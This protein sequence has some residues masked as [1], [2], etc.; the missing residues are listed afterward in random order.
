MKSSEYVHL[1]QGPLEIECDK[2]NR[3][4]LRHRVEAY[5]CFVCGGRKIGQAVTVWKFSHILAIWDEIE[6]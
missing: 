6:L 1:W 3:I 2:C 4:S 5:C